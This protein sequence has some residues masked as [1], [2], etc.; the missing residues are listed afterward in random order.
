MRSFRGALTALTV[1]AASVLLPAQQSEAG[2]FCCLRR[3]FIP[4][5]PCDPCAS[6][7]PGCPAPIVQEGSYCNP[8]APCTTS[9]VRRTYLEPQTC[10]TTRCAVE[11]APV[12]VRRSYWAPCE[13][14]Y[15]C[16]WETS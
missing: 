12:V 8:C 3:V 4:C 5:D 9:Y 14:R 7:V 13:C 10:Y 1:T 16:Y 11:A 6:P 2:I 15:K